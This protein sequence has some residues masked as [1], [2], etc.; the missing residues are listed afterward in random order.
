MTIEAKE[1]SKKAHEIVVDFA[2]QITTISSAILSFFVS[3]IAA[4]LID[5]SAISKLTIS[6]AFIGLVLAIISSF[7]VILSVAGTLDAVAHPDR[8]KDSKEASQDS[9]IYR[10]NIR[11]PL[12]AIVG[13][14]LLGISAM[15]I[16]IIFR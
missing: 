3:L 4:K 8:S 5:F 11:I 6:I 12:W 13:F 15:S 10:S 7:W 9:S 1:A 2:K 14:F 16:S